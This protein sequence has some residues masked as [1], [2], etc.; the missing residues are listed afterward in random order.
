MLDATTIQAITDTVDAAQTK[1]KPIPMLTIEH[2][3]LSLDDGYAVMDELL[4]RWTARGREFYGFK[5]G[6]TSRAKMDQMGVDVPC[7]GLMMRDTCDPDGGIIP[8]AGLIHPRVEAE[9]AFVMKEDLVGPEVSIEQVYA[10][11]DYVQPAIEIIDSRFEN[12]K[13]DLASVVAD[14]CSS[15]RLVMGGRMRRPEELDLAALGVVLEVNGEPLAYAAS[16]AVLGHPANVIQLL[17]RWLHRRG[18][19]L[20]AGTVVLTGAVTEAHFIHPGDT[21]CARFQDMGTINVKVS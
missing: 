20:K 11:T 19:V 7:F 21:I 16:G 14:N 1:A 8:T 10:A 18:E 3:E 12:F 17:V 9:I 15:A 4:R 6:L 5:A 13:F 2:P